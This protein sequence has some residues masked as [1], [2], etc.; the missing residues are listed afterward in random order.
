MWTAA[1]ARFRG[2]KALG[3][4]T[5]WCW[6]FGGTHNEE[7]RITGRR[8]TCDSDRAN[9]K[10]RG[11]DTWGGMPPS[12]RHE[13]IPCTFAD[14]FNKMRRGIF[15][16]PFLLL[17]QRVHASVPKWTRNTSIETNGTAMQSSIKFIQRWK[18]QVYKY[19]PSRIRFPMSQPNYPT[20]NGRVYGVYTSHARFVLLNPHFHGKLQYV[21]RCPNLVNTLPHGPPRSGYL[22]F[23][24]KALPFLGD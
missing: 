12:P 21:E 19:L 15:V 13:T 10:C 1:V 22:D 18:I 20:Y 17:Q 14:A 16:G 8:R 3:K 2:E 24:A 6:D 5:R 7:M 4:E 11:F 9:M 23:R